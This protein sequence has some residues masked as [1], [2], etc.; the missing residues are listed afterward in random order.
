MTLLT[1][2]ALTAL[3][4]PQRPAT[5][6]NVC[7]TDARLGGIPNKNPGYASGYRYILIVNTELSNAWQERRHVDNVVPRG[8]VT[9][10]PRAL[11]KQ[12]S[13]TTNVPAVEIVI[14]TTQ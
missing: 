9:I 6:S 13:H 8:Y 10:L 2:G 1:A 3:P 5:A 12:P 4:D 7:T 11:V 14:S